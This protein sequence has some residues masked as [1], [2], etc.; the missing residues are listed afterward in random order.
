MQK[1]P[2]DKCKFRV[3][4]IEHD[5]YRFGDTYRIPEREFLYKHGYILV[6]SNV[7]SNGHV[8]EDWWV[9]PELVKLNQYINFVCNGKEYSD[10]I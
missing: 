2:F 8:Y 4:T 1:I 9:H 6:T 10:I 3:I 7:N 5:A